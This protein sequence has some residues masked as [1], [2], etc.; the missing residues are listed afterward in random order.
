MNN[1][2]RKVIRG[3]IRELKKPGPDWN[4]I[5]SELTDILDEES[6]TIENIPESLQD[7]DRYQVCEESI[8]YLDNAIGEID[9]E[10][11]ECAET[12]IGILEQINGI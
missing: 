2:R 1:A 10:D 12:I 4:M 3:V 8:D 11:P 7:T 9:P 6:E 5:E